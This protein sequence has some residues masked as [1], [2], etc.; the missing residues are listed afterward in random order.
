M[1]CFIFQMSCSNDV[2]TQTASSP[3]KRTIVKLILI[4]GGFCI[5]YMQYILH[6]MY[7]ALL[8][9]LFNFLFKLLA[10]Q[11]GSNEVQLPVPG[12]FMPLWENCCFCIQRYKGLQSKASTW[13]MFPALGP[14]SHF[15]SPES[16]MAKISIKGNWSYIVNIHFPSLTSIIRK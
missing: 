16:K 12:C 10:L 7:L 2:N 8:H 4:S 13:A 6:C 1:L 15:I 11:N 9:W 5:I 14:R 3:L